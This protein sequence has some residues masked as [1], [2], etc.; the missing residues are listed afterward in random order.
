MSQP[1]APGRRT[2]TER[3]RFR[4]LDRPTV[5]RIRSPHG[6]T[7]AVHL[8]SNGRY[9]VM[10]TAAGSGYSR[11][12]D[13]GIT[14]WR[15]DTTCDDWGSYIF[16]RD[17]RSGQVWSAGYQ[18][19]GIA[20]DSSD[21]RFSEDKV[22]YT[23]RDGAI[24]TV[25]EVL[26][27]S[28]HDAEVRRLFVTNAGLRPREI[29]ITSYA[30]L[31]LAPPAADAA[32]PAFSKLFVQT[33]YDAK[34][35]VLLA[36][37]RR[38]SPSEPEVWAAHLAIVEGETVGETEIETDRA[39]FLGRGRD[40]AIADGRDG[41]PALSGSVGTVLDPIF[42]MRRRVRVQPGETVRIAFWTIVAPSRADVLD[43]VDKHQDANAFDRAATLAWTQAQVQLRHLDIDAEEASLFQ[44]LAGHVLYASPSMRPS[45]DI[46]RRGSG[47]PAG[48]WAQSISGD[49]PIVLVRID[50]IEDIAVVGQLL[51]AHEY[52]RM[53]GWPSIS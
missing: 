53:K 22:E 28:E 43:L 42:A 32:H 5:R 33:E 36:T 35:G 14:R 10:L 27:S 18:P 20:P 21:V 49:I 40:D 8:L 45:S 34:T 24:T 39:R 51:R 23:R 17:V 30:E 2:P 37:R 41:R 19:S 15:E 38:R 44:R 25:L 13:I 50:D 52:W 12:R 26:V 6:P 31:V 29:E 7:P 9:A 16:L 46:I 48:L 3:R 1:P 11:W 4:V 47:D